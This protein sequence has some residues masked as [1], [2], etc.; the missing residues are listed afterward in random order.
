MKWR[1]KMD[2]SIINNK[3]LKLYQFNVK[4]IDTIYALSPDFTLVLFHDRF[5]N[6]ETK[7]KASGSASG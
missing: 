1:V 3:L 7:A 4:S 2:L 6:G 5:G